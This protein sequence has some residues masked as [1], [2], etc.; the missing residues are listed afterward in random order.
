MRRDAG[1][2]G[3]SLVETLVAVL[4][5]SVVS[6]AFLQVLISQQRGVDMTRTVTRLTDEARL[7]FNR[8]IRDAREGDAL[9]AASPTSFTVKVNYDG[10]G[11]YE[12]PTASGVYEILTYAYDPAAATITLN[13]S[14]L[15]TNVYPI[16][17]GVDIFTY[18]SNNLEYDWGGDGLVTWLDVDKA[19]SYGHAG[20]GD[21]SGTLTSA[22]VRHLTSI[23]FAL[24][25]GSGN[26][27]VPFYAKTQMRNRV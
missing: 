27:A 4:V 6:V 11:V 15:M 23:A 14:V 26:Q 13:G 22:E 5:F 12:N 18:S 20:V 2:E 21:N 17:P 8:M 25:I 3:F 7:G 16:A 9:S 24:K 10:N 1:E 19:V